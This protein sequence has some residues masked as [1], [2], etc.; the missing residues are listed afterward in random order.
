MYYTPWNVSVRP[1]QVTYFVT[2][3]DALIRNKLHTFVQL[4]AS[5]PNFSIRSL[6]LSD[7]FYK[8]PFFSNYATLAYD[9]DCMQFQYSFLFQYRLRVPLISYPVMVCD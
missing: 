2:T 3:F 8:S 9:H 5:S 6:Q 4:C 1:H 7:A